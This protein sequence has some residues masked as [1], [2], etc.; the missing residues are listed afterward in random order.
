MAN[1]NKSFANLRVVFQRLQRNF[2]IHNRH[3]KR[4]LVISTIS[5]G[6]SFLFCAKKWLKLE[7]PV[8]SPVVYAKVI[9]F[10]FTTVVFV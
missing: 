2:E 8:L 5:G 9:K 10:L 4:L 3:V 7:F 1:V 6:A